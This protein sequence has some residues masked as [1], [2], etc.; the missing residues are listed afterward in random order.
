LS[1]SRAR[2]LCVLLVGVLPSCGKRGDPLPPLP[3][4][5]QA[6]AAF[7]VAQ[8]AGVL[9]VS[10]VAPRLTTAGEVLGVVDLELL[11]LDGPG[12]LD[13]VGRKQRFRAAPGER[14]SETYPLPPVGTPVKMAAR[15]V[16]R[17]QL[18]VM[19]KLVSLVVQ[20]PPPPP[21]TL[22]AKLRPA[23]VSLTW[24]MPV[25]PPRPAP[26][27]S[28]SPAV[29][30]TPSRSPSASPSPSPSASPSAAATPAPSPT[31]P[32]PPRVRLYRRAGTSGEPAPI[33]PEPLAGT[34]FEDTG[35]AQGQTW[36]YVARLVT[37]TDP[38]VESANS[39]EACVEVKD[40]FPP[41]VPTGLSALLQDAEV[42]VSWSPSADPDLKAYRLY[43]AT[44][45]GAPQRVAEVE[46]GTTTA[47]DTPAAGALHV[48]TLTAVDQHG[49]ESA[50]SAP[51]EVRRQ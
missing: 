3:R 47:R 1:K 18:S 10:M 38:L 9:E 21:P 27:P 36:C 35:A 34:N 44:A 50:P 41:A 37:A 14:I 4:T 45:G 25:M 15:A 23:G 51:A 5:P 33:T 43:R 48:Y 29:S 17:G 46:K 16:H 31:P 13:K 20:P 12:E 6:V 2:F 39:P 49:N 26:T 7:T 28:P 42:E 30:P 8:R 32:P 40:V 19:G 22:E 24:S 11:R